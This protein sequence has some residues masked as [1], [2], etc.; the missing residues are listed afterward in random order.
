MM[1]ELERRL[2]KLEA[3]RVPLM[4]CCIVQHILDCEPSERPQRLAAIRAAE[5]EAFHIVRVVIDPS[6][7]RQ[8]A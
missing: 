7:S 1:R 4:H 3:T 8:A 5:P 2:A 6:E